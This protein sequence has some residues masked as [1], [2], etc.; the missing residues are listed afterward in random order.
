MAALDK[1][2][3]WVDHYGRGEVS[4]KRAVEDFIECE[5]AEAVKPF[6]AQL[7]TISKGDYDPHVLE[8]LLG[9]KR[10]ARHGSLENW[11]K[12]MLGWAAS[13]KG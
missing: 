13:Y 3:Y 2:Q 12:L 6:K 1:I 5:T 8:P 10:I 4:D 11:A 7:H 9:K